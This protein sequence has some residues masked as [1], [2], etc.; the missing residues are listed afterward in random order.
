MLEF[1]VIVGVGGLV[2]GQVVYETSHDD[3]G[4]RD[5]EDGCQLGK[6]CEK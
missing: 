6:N 4:V 5:D 2:G 3:H 1:E